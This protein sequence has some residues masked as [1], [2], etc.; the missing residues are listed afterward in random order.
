[1]KDDW[2]KSVTDFLKRKP[3]TTSPVLARRP[4]VQISSKEWLN[5]AFPCR[6]CPPTADKRRGYVPVAGE[7]DEDETSGAG[8]YGIEPLGCEEACPRF[9][10]WRAGHEP[11]QEAPDDVEILWKEWFNPVFPCRKCPTGSLKIRSYIPRVSDRDK[12]DPVEGGAYSVSALGCESACP[13]FM[14]WRVAHPLRRAPG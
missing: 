13:L 11:G 4:G 9:Q 6:N 5:P 8:L 2:I 14:T 7:S 10:A 12:D 3:N 1:M